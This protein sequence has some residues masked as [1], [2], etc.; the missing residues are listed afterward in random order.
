MADPITLL[1]LGLAASG[2]AG[3]IGSLTAP[4][5][6]PISMPAQA[7]PVQQ[8]QGSASTYKGG[9]P[10]FLSA[11]AATPQQQNTASKTLLGQ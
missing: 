1:G 9:Q 10:S 8:P 11:A 5:P 3:A 4:K 2:A 6:P 7:P